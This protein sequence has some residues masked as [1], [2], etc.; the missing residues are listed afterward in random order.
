MQI[1]QVGIESQSSES[2]YTNAN[3]SKKVTE[4][5]SISKLL[6]GPEGRDR[7][8]Q[9]VSILAAKLS[10]AMKHGPSFQ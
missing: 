7:S 4:L 1:V 3:A 5:L 9:S 2:W 10:K 8:T 6:L